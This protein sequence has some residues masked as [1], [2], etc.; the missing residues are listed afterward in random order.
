MKQ[1]IFKTTSR[2]RERE[3]KRERE[4]ERERCKTMFYTIASSKIILTVK[5]IASSKDEESMDLEIIF[6]KY[7]E[8]GL[9]TFYIVS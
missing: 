4:R 9:I 2:E 8:R 6:G 5:I 7:C 1:F 3:R